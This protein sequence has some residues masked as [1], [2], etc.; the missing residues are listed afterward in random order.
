[1][2]IYLICGICGEPILPDHWSVF[3]DGDH[4]HGSCLA[5]VDEG[6]MHDRDMGDS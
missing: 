1:M 2:S 3:D 4:V 6:N 5:D